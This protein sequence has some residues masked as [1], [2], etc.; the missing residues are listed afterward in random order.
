MFRNSGLLK[1]WGWKAL[2]IRSRA[3]GVGFPGRGDLRVQELNV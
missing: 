1:S 2:G 3:L